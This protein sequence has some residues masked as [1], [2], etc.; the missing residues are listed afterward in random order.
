M[1][2]PSTLRRSCAQPVNSGQLVPAAQPATAVL[3]SFRRIGL[4]LFLALKA[5]FQ[6][7]VTPSSS[8]AG[9]FYCLTCQGSE[10]DLLPLFFLSPRSAFSGS[11]LSVRTRSSRT[12]IRDGSRFNGLGASGRRSSESYKRGA[13]GD[14]QTCLRKHDRARSGG[15]DRESASTAA[16]PR[17]ITTAA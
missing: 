17:P 10:S 14:S 11:R 1:I 16:S 15:I 3:I 9:I 12:D 7:P 8:E 13:G 5:S 6:F 2:P 4:S